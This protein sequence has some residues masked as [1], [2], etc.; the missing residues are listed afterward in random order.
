M[1]ASCHTMEIVTI[2]KWQPGIEPPAPIPAPIPAA[3]PP[4]RKPPGPPP[5]REPPALIINYPQTG[6]K[7]LPV[8]TTKIHVKQKKVTL[9]DGTEESIYAARSLETCQSLLM[10]ADQPVDIRLTRRGTLIF[11][12]TIFPEWTR[13][14]DVYGF[15]N[16]EIVTT[17][18]TAFHI[19]LAEDP[20]GVPEYIPDHRLSSY[21]GLGYNAADDLVAIKKVIDGVTYQR[22]IIDPDVADRTVVR[23]VEYSEWSVI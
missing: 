18:E 21:T 8:G 2:R 19:S 14:T 3:I 17:A 6:R 11:A 4:A 16:I 7:I 5:E 10:Y 23:E 20:D 9:P 1:N 13:M 15:A 22:D 12:S